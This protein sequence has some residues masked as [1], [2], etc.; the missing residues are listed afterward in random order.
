VDTEGW[1]KSKDEWIV[2]PDKLATNHA[3]VADNIAES[4]CIF[5][6]PMLGKSAKKA[7]QPFMY[8]PCVSNHLKEADLERNKDIINAFLRGE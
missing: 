7:L 8:I 5:F 6:A 1:K 4:Q 2:P 3:R